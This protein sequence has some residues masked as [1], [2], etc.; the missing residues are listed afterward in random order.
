LSQQS[1]LTW[2]R[3][4]HMVLYIKANTSISQRTNFL[5]DA[6][7]Q[8]LVEGTIFSTIQTDI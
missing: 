3:K 5:C 4:E 1:F 8:Y 2:S 6:S 7:S